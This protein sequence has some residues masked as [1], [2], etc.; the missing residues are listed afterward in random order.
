MHLH[1]VEQHLI[2]AFNAGII[3]RRE[4]LRSAGALRDLDELL[5]RLPSTHKGNLLALHEFKRAVI[6]Q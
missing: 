6:E 4:Y 1:E 3:G 2:L 5:E